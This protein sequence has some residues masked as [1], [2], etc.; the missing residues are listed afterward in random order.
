[1]Q[2]TDDKNHAIPGGAGFAE[3]RLVSGHA[4]VLE[5]FWPNQPNV[6]TDDLKAQL[7]ASN[8]QRR[9]ILYPGLMLS[10]ATAEKSGYVREQLSEER[11]VS[12]Q[13]LAAANRAR[14]SKLREAGF[15]FPAPASA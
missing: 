1:M 14:R 7:A 5:Q 10:L 9:A 12:L 15:V 8:Q 6:L 11:A 13:Q 3:S 4:G 2:T